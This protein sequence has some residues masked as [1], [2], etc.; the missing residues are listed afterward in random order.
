VEARRRIRFQGS[1]QSRSC[2]MPLAARLKMPSIQS[3]AGP[4]LATTA[5]TRIATDLSRA[6]Q[7]RVMLTCVTIC[8][9]SAC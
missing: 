6:P 8:C 5:G 7:L 2:G 3:V 4:D 9:C 1:S